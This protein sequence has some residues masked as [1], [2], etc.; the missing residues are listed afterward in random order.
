MLK[1]P[2]K[3]ISYVKEKVRDKFIRSPQELSD[4]MLE[5]IEKQE[6]ETGE[7]FDEVRV[8]AET[9]PMIYQLY[10]DDRAIKNHIKSTLRQSN[11][12][13]RKEIKTLWDRF[14]RGN[15]LNL[16]KNKEEELKEI[17]DED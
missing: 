6:E 9:L 12:E 1:T 11:P 16:R 8:Y 14:N 17:L 4:K 5:A 3:A 15:K 13:L 10:D 7:D 2:K